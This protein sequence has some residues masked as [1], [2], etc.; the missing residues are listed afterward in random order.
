MANSSKF[1]LQLP[2][3]PSLIPPSHTGSTWYHLLHSGSVRRPSNQS[4]RVRRSFGVPALHYA[5]SYFTLKA[6]CTLSGYAA[7]SDPAYVLAMSIGLGTVREAPP[8]PQ[9]RLT[10]SLHTALRYGWISKCDT[11]CLHTCS[12]GKFLYQSSAT[13]CHLFSAVD[14]STPIRLAC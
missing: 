4:S 5:R 9:Q 8:A 13:A 2:S 6:P 12:S 1:E 7:S 14:K 3:P 11:N 10:A